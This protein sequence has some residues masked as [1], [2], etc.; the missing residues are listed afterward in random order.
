[1]LA[2]DLDPPT[3]VFFVAEITDMHYH[4]SLFVNMGVLIAWASLE[5]RSSQSLLP[6]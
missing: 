2:L 1:M 4:P 6:K 5:T 3:Y